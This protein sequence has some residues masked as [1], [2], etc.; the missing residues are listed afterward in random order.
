MEIGAPARLVVR[1]LQ[2]A[3]PDVLD[4]FETLALLVAVRDFLDEEGELP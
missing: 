3:G 2:C 4:F 1:A